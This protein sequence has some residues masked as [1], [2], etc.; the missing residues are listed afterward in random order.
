MFL[1]SE[2]TKA[3]AYLARGLIDGSSLITTTFPFA[4]AHQAFSYK[5]HTPSAKVVLV[6]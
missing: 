6:N 4:D 3:A 5:A 2:F 1:D